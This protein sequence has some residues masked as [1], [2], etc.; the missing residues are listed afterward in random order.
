M[1]E[2]TYTAALALRDDSPATVGEVNGA[3]RTRLEAGGLMAFAVTGQAPDLDCWER[4]QPAW[5]DL[6]DR[7]YRVMAAQMRAGDVAQLPMFLAIVC[8]DAEPTTLVATATEGRA[9]DADGVLLGAY[10][11]GGAQMDAAAALEA[12]GLAAPEEAP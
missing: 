6:E 4:S 3:P 5:R 8:Q 2:Y 10:T 1:T 12:L 9:Y 11:I 7:P